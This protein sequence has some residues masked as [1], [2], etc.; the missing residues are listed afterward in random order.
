MRELS[1]HLLDLLEN[2]IRA[3]ANVI[4][5]TIEGDAQN[6]TLRLSV[7]D[8]GKGFAVPPEV[9]ASPFYTTSGSKRTGLGL[10]LLS[11]A[12]QQAGGGMTLGRSELLGGAAVE[13]V[14][15]LSHIDRAPLGDLAGTVAAIV[16]THPEADICVELRF[17]GK[18]LA[19]RSAEL[20]ASLP[21]DRRDGLAVARLIRQALRSAPKL[22][23]PASAG[24][25]AG[26]P[27]SPDG[28]P[29]GKPSKRA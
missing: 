5:V 16:C 9:A 18:R 21:P 7:Q 22:D 20:A 2:S 1:L 25:L 13:A 6:D 19:I 8:N 3:G 27:A 24:A 28:P 23:E 29:P 10:S 15:G 14:M 11:A 26:G 12:A 4:S 17:G